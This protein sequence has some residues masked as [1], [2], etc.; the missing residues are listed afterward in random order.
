MFGLELMEDVNRVLTANENCNELQTKLTRVL[1]G[2]I[3]RNVLKKLE[4]SDVR[5]T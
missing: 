2:L 5:F 4:L 3:S 1:L